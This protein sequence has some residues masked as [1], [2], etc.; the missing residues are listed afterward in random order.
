M[1]TLA[2]YDKVNLKEFRSVMFLCCGLG[3]RV[4]GLGFRV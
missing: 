4:S 1:L 3:F 2:K